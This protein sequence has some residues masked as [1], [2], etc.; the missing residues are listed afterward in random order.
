MLRSLWLQKLPQ[1]IQEVLVILEEVHLDKLATY[2]DKIAERAMVSAI[3]STS[4]N[5]SISTISTSE[6]SA[7]TEQ[8]SKLIAKVDARQFPRKKG[9]RSR[10]SSRTRESSRTRDE[11]ICYYHRRF[12]DKAKYI[13]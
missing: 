10:S 6:V 12:K 1:H 4:P 9:R 7:L 8:I 3:T 5:A 11:S 13:F 2:A